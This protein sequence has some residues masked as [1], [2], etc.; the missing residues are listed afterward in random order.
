MLKVFQMASSTFSNR[1][2]Q[3]YI[4]PSPK[5]AVMGQLPPFLRTRRRSVIQARTVR[6]RIPM[7]INNYKNVRAFNKDLQ[8]VCPMSPDGPRYQKQ[9][10]T[11]VL[12]TPHIC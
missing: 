1:A 8:T 12:L 6:T 11:E 2:T 9:S 3:V 5:L 7:A 4:A 10:Q